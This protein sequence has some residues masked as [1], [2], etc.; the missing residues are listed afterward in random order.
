MI[1]KYR[2]APEAEA[3][4]DEIWLYIARES[5]SIP[6][7]NR[8]VDSITDRFWLLVRQPY[9]G[10]S[11]DRQLRRGLRSFAVGNYLIVYR[12]E[13]DGAIVI[14]NIPHGKQNTTGWLDW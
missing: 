12:I 6:T 2:L 9:L 14:L 4:L 3:D 5:G 7:A 10:R 1:G 13:A 11:R 8:V